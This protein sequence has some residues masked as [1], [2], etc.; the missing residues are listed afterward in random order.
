MKGSYGTAGSALLL[1]ALVVEGCAGHA[2]ARPTGAVI[3]EAEP[4]VSL[5]GLLN[6]IWNGEPHFMLLDDRGHAVRLMIDDA[7]LKPFGGVQALVQKHITVAGK[8][9][10]QTPEVIEV[11]S[12]EIVGGSK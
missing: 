6:V 3:A 9:V 8:R 11:L 5:S 2:W 10:S 7:L 1:V 12:I 4:R